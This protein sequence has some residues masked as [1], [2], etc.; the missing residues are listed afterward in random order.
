MKCTRNQNVLYIF[1]KIKIVTYYKLQK[2]LKMLEETPYSYNG[3][4]HNI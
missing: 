3:W 1:K 2:Y 4:R